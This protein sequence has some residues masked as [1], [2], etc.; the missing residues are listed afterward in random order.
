[1]KK[2]VAVYYAPASAMAQMANATPE[3][4]AAGMAPWMDWKARAGDAIVDF[5]APLM[6][7]HQLDPSG[8]WSGST[9]EVTGYSILQ[10][11]SIEEVK[12]LFAG[13]PHLSWAPGC[14]IDVHE[15]AEM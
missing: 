1:M 6:P 11:N 8:N 13:H 15:A 5:G 7:G 4:K 14:S 12:A 9:N 2:F 10:G 3:Q